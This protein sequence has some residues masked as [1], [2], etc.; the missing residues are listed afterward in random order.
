MGDGRQSRIND[1]Y[2]PHDYQ[3]R[4]N[5]VKEY[6]DHPLLLV[7]IMLDEQL[8]EIDHGVAAN[9]QEVTRVENTVSGRLPG[10]NHSMTHL[11]DNA[12][13][14]LKGSIKLLDAV[15]WMSRAVSMLLEAGTELDERVSKD[16]GPPSKKA[17]EVSSPSPL[18]KNWVSMKQYLEDMSRLCDSLEADPMMSEKR[19]Q[20]QIDIVRV[21]HLG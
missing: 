5:D 12:H 3:R 1:D 4:L 10:E 21:C 11:M 2:Q 6:W 17:G 18:K 8:T 16:V 19:C 15:H 20:A 9:N 7:M 13:T 14:A